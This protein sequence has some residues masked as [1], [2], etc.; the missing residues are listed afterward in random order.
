M[1]SHYYVLYKWVGYDCCENKV[2]I[3]EKGI[4]KL[5]VYFEGII[6]KKNIN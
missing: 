1:G 2:T 6:S 5:K 3:Y 4:Q